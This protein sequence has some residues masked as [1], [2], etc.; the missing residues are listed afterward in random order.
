MPRPFPG[1]RIIPEVDQPGHVGF[2]WNFPE[3]EEFL[4]CFGNE[5]WGQYCVEPPCGQVSWAHGR[6]RWPQLHLSVVH[7][8]QEHFEF[9]QL[10]PVKPGLDD[11]LE[12]IYKELY[13]NMPFDTF[14]LGADEVH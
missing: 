10:N 1:I 4:C 5:P 3:A 8:L 13:D 12:S 9:F 11:I 6:V 7:T 14:H 2:G